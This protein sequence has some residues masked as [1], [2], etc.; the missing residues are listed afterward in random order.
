MLGE[1]DLLPLC[2]EALRSGKIVAFPKFISALTSPPSPLNVRLASSPQEGCYSAVQILDLQKDL[3]PGQ[4]GIPEPASNLPKSTL[5]VLD[6]IFVPGIGFNFD[7]ARLGRGKGYYDR[8][9]STISGIRCG[10]AFDWQIAAE[11]PCEAHDIRLDCVVTPSQWRN[12]TDQ[13]AK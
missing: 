6:L 5:N 10:V 4:F 11:L 7:G 13:P 2:H 8:L 12:I 9:L 3:A 1:P